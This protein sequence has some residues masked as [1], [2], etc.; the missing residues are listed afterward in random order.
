MGDVFDKDVLG[1]HVSLRTLDGGVHVH[2]A[3][4]FIDVIN[5]ELDLTKIDEYEIVFRTITYEWFT[6]LMKKEGKLVDE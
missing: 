1:G 3:K 2:Q 4:T 5:G 6:N